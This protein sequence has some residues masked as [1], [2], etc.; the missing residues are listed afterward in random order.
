MIKAD[1]SEILNKSNALIIF[2]KKHVKI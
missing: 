1:K 2:S